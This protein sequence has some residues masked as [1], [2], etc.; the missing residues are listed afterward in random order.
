MLRPRRL[1][2]SP[3][4]LVVIFATLLTLYY[5]GTTAWSRLRSTPPPGE[6][7]APLAAS[8]DSRGRLKIPNGAPG[9]AQRAQFDLEGERQR[10]G[11]A[12]AA[13]NRELE[14]QRQKQ[15]DKAGRKALN[16]AGGGGDADTEDDEDGEEDAAPMGRAPQ[17]WMAADEARRA[18]QKE[19]DERQRGREAGA[20]DRQREM[21]RLRAARPPKAVVEQK[22]MRV[23]WAQQQQEQRQKPPPPPPPPVREPQAA[24]APL[25]EDKPLRMV[26]E[27]LR[28]QGAHKA[29]DPDSPPPN[30]VKGVPQAQKNTYEEEI[31]AI[32]NRRARQGAKMKEWDERVAAAEDGDHKKGGGGLKMDQDDLDGVQKGVAAQRAAAAGG[33]KKG[34]L[35]Q[36]GGARNAAGDDK[37][38]RVAPAKDRGDAD[39]VVKGWDQRF[40]KPAAALAK[41][42]DGVGPRDADGDEA[43]EDPTAT[44]T[45]ETGSLDE[46]GDDDVAKHHLVRRIAAYDFNPKQ[47]PLDSEKPTEED[48][49]R[50]V[51]PVNPSDE[52]D[53]PRRFNLTVCAFIPH[54]KRFLGEWL[55]YHRLLG[56][57]QFALYDTSHPGVFG[58]AEIDELIDK[59]K[60][61][62]GE[63][64][65]APTIEELKAHVGTAN[66]DL[67]GLDERGEI[68]KEKIAGFERWIDQG[69]A[70]VHWMNFGNAREARDPHTAMLEHCV[71]TYSSSSEWLA[72]LDVDEFLSLAPSPATSDAPSTESG[73][74]TYPLHDLLASP[75]LSDAACV[76]LPLLNYRN[77]GIR[78]LPYTQGVLEAQVR[79][80]VIRNSDTG[81]DATR[82]HQRILLHT[83][84]SE[85]SSVSFAGAHSCLVSSASKT[86]IKTS[87]GTLLQDGGRYKAVS[88]PI[89]P[90]AVAH[91]VQR[92]L[93]DCF[94]KLSSLA[95]PNDLH[96]RSRGMLSCEE[97]YIPTPEEVEA[98]PY[99]EQNRFLLKSPPSDTILL[100]RRIADSWPAR[101]TREIRQRWQAV[102][103]KLPGRGRGQG[104]DRDQVP[105]DIVDRAR[106]KVAIVNLKSRPVDRSDEA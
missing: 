36:V 43:S 34:P 51:A 78:E 28:Q 74:L 21:D 33:R 15:R 30:A 41:G 63:G 26:K 66:S 76:P 42:G 38:G 89:E 39:R 79:R 9:A 22:A 72:Q 53:A 32:A 27:P 12:R 45:S 5:Y 68:R 82:N 25:V 103:D 104:G 23:P 56:V 55:L 10:F 67:G 94:A 61:E 44:T 24:A 70:K 83:A 2:S 105:K 52:K 80:D 99:N 18:A 75:E 65:L 77:Y 93:R 7:G 57:E 3:L 58:A 46:H 73:T 100:D 17:R 54:E 88:I 37:G 91:Y 40:K 81:V 71:E 16:A 6:E 49:L 69:A 20:G 11:E 62:S 8:T 29:A 101:A 48:S 60:G 86:A 98:L 31:E 90:L 102:R 19:H 85:D 84:F 1:L 14:R 50:V 95:D 4:K 59:M 87:D 64:E 47:I 96:P 13:R 92:D 97:H 35:I 106:R